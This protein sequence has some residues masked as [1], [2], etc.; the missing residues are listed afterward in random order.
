MK[1]FSTYNFLQTHELPLELCSQGVAFFACI[2]MMSLVEEKI[3][4]WLVFSQEKSCCEQGP[5]DSEE[6]VGDLPIELRHL[7]EDFCNMFPSPRSSHECNLIAFCKGITDLTGRQIQAGYVVVMCRIPSYNSL[8]SILNWW[9]TFLSWHSALN[10][11]LQQ[12]TQNL[13]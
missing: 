9:K 13:H 4:I 12:L 8:L 10:Y 2:S 7:E 6:S 3:N 5:N 1:L 11:A